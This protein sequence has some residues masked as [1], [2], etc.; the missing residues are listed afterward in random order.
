[1]TPSRAHVGARPDP[2][3]LMVL[4]LFLLAAALLTAGP[5]RAGRNDQPPPPRYPEVAM[6]LANDL[7]RQAAPRL[8][9]GFPDNSRGLYWV[10]VTVP[11]EAGN[12]EASSGLGRLMAQELATALVAWGY[13]VQEIRKASE[14]AFSRGQGEFILTRDTRAL[15][16]RQVA[17]T[18]VVAGTYTVLPGEVRFTM[19]V[20][21]ARNNNI[22]AMSSQ[23]LARSPEVAA[24]LG[25][26]GLS[27]VCPTVSTVDPE[28]F[29]RE[30]MPYL[31]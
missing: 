24:L 15:A 19:E 12:L 3:T 11:A 4:A 25:R 26:G 6:A 10:V 29:R 31:R 13:N 9:I 8:G 7:D 18:L 20:I 22:V 16:R 14:I 1:M 21:D 5:V 27:E 2:R 28:V 30:I 23:S 17:A